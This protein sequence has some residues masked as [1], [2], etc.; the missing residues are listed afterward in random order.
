MGAVAEK[1]FRD[2]LTSRRFIVLLG[3]ML[4]VT[5]LALLQ[6]D[7]GSI[8]W[9]GGEQHQHVYE[10]M[11]GVTSYITL[12][13]AIFALALGFDV[14]T[15]EYENRTMKVLMGHPVFRDQVVLGKF[16]GGALILAFSTIITALV[17][18]GA[19][20]W[21][22]VT[23]DSM[24]RIAVYFATIYLYLLVFFTMAMAFSAYCR[25]SGNALMYSLIAFLTVTI[26]FSSIAP[27][28]AGHIAG[29]QPKMPAEAKLLQEKLN[30]LSSSGNLSAEQQAEI[31]ELSKKYDTIMKEYQNETMKWSKRYWNLQEEIDAISP[32]WDLNEIST[33]I[34]N[35]QAKSLSEM[36]E[37]R[38]TMQAGNHEYTL[39]QSLSFVKKQ[40]IFLFA[41]LVVGFVAAYLGFVRA[42]IR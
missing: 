7:Y 33:Y 19:L 20:M 10:V 12:V 42:E 36:M 24:A 28:V 26:V 23:I 29:P 14:I 34:L 9:G 6:V 22:G 18:V 25:S 5:L 31:M 27:I 35:P 13:G 16:L 8:S 17:V 4:A 37:Y 2:Y 11:I 39:G 15:K 40:Y 30:R 38:G 21:M 41:Y 1:E 32:M 3:F